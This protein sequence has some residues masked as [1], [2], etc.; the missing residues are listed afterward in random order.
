[1][2]T[3]IKIDIRA[4][5]HKIIHRPLCNIDCNSYPSDITSQACHIIIHN[6]LCNIDWAE[7]NNLLIM[8]AVFIS[9]LIKQIREHII[10]DIYHYLERH[11]D[12][13]SVDKPGS[14]PG[15]SGWGFESPQ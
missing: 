12:G 11:C 15:P 14:N 6:P 2:I 1:L 3:N 8:N 10:N 13:I 7:K 4:K 9:Q 5:V